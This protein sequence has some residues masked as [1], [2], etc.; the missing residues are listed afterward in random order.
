MCSSDLLSAVLITADIRRN[1]DRLCA[2]FATRIRCVFSF[3]P[4][5]PVVHSD[6]GPAPRKLQR[7]RPPD[8]GAAAG[9]DRSE[10][11][12]SELQSLMRISYAVFCLK[13]KR[14]GD[15]QCTS[16]PTRP[17]AMPYPYCNTGNHREEHMNAQNFK[18]TKSP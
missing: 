13:T 12:T 16:K 18:H 3:I 9:D 11:H 17:T 7:R 10:E 2:E 14:K 15:K 6:I 5:D 1:R 8:T 4:A